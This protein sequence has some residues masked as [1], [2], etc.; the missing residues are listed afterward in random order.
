MVV[1]NEL[2]EIV[3]RQY[4]FSIGGLYPIEV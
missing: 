1:Y 4:S 3:N 2:L